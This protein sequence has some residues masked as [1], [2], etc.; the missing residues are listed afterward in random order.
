MPD[1]IVDG[2]V[3]ALDRHW[4][5]G[6]VAARDRREMAGDVAADLV[7]AVRSGVDPHLLLTPDLATFADSV[8]IARNVEPVRVERGR[9][10]LGLVLGS[11]VLLA[12][13]ALAMPYVRRY[14]T[15]RVQ[16]KSPHPVGGVVLAGSVLALLVLGGALAG[17]RISLIGR[18]AARDTVRRAAAL[19]LSGTVTAALVAL[20]LAVATGF[21]TSPGAVVADIVVGVGTCG[22]GA[23][24]A[25][26]SALLHADDLTT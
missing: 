1:P 12:A 25:R 18:P 23:I 19:L 16:L 4:I 26:R 21:R 9:V 11:A 3:T 10:L 17:L 20:A 2:L 14:L 7:E 24:Y 13:A 22:A 15:R 5:R 6:G 8:A